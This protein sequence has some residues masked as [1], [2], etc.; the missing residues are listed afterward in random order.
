MRSEILNRGIC[1]LLAALV[2]AAIAAGTADAAEPV[3]YELPPATH[4]ATLAIGSDGTAWWSPGRGTEYKGSNAMIGKVEPDGTVTELPVAG[5]GSIA[6]TTLGPGGELWLTGDDTS[7]KGRG[8]GR[9]ARIAIG[10]AGK[11]L[12]AVP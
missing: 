2:M 5:L 8:P 3:L 4:A 10:S 9:R 7:A 1:C 12:R 6:S 11:S